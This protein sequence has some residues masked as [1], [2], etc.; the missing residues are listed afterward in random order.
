MS[1]FDEMLPASYRGVPFVVLG[2]E[3]ENGRRTALHEYPYKDVGWPED[4][5]RSLRR[6]E[7]VGFLI[8]DNVIAQRDAMIAA[9]E[10]AGDGL[11]I[12]PTYGSM[13]VNLLTPLRSGER[14]DKGRYVELRFGFIEAGKKQYPASIVATG[15]AV[16]AAA[17][18]ADAAARADFITTANSALAHGATVVTRAV[19]TVVLWAHMAQRLANDATN[20]YNRVGAL[21]GSYG[22]YFSGRRQGGFSGFVNGVNGVVPTINSLINQG[23]IARTQVSNA[24]STLVVLAQG[25]SR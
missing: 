3:A 15:A 21:Q 8:G 1:F 18:G 5:G 6:I 23:S 4:L 2:T 16:Q 11:L 10:T 7:I 19:D 9:C 12:H 20:L 13:Q 24:A 25:L 17:A 22:R 14:W